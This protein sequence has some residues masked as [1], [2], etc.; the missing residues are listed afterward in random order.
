MPTIDEFNSYCNG[1]HIAC[2]AGGENVFGRGQGAEID[3]HD[4]VVRF[5][6]AWPREVFWPDV[7]KRTDC[8]C[9]ATRSQ[10]LHR[11]GFE[12][13]WDELKYVLWPWIDVVDMWPGLANWVVRFPPEFIMQLGQ[14]MDCV[15][16]NGAAVMVWLWSQTQCAIVDMYGMDFF[17][18]PDWSYAYIPTKPRTVYYGKRPGKMMGLHD[19]D[20]ERAWIKANKPDCVRYHG[21]EL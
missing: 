6:W 13:L 8:W 18:T 10:D 3:A 20:K 12:V 21:F 4:I 2:V 14:E 17:T 16:T 11:R 15:P 9:C 1:K 7:G 19:L 5:N